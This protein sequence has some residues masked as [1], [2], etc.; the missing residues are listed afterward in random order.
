MHQLDRVHSC[1]YIKPSLLAQVLQRTF[2]RLL[3]IRAS[4][5]E[6][7]EARRPLSGRDQKSIIWIAVAPALSPLSPQS[8]VSSY[9]VACL[10]NSGCMGNTRHRR[11]ARSTE[12]GSLLQLAATCLMCACLLKRRRCSTAACFGAFVKSNTGPTVAER[13]SHKAEVPA[14]TYRGPH[15]GLCLPGKAAVCFTR[16]VRYEELS[17]C[18]VTYRGTSQRGE[19]SDMTQALCSVEERVDDP[20]LSAFRSVSVSIESDER[21]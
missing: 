1:P 13:Y 15:A 3:C 6:R 20:S 2:A 14:A 11:H 17:T 10:T 21:L 9:P 12:Q 19:A 5:R 8:C 4:Q 18:R 7:L 16:S